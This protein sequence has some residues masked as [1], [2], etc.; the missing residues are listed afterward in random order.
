M[1]VDKHPRDFDYWAVD[2]NKHGTFIAKKGKHQPLDAT[3]SL[4]NVPG[5]N[6]STVRI[7]RK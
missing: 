4:R 7:E 6:E 1:S 3:D 2:D 5:N